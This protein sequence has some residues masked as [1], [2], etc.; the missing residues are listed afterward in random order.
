M[1][2]EPDGGGK[3]NTLKLWSVCS[4]VPVCVC[5]CEHEAGGGRTVWNGVILSLWGCQRGCLFI[6]CVHLIWKQESVRDRRV[7]VMLRIYLFQRV[8]NLVVILRLWPPPA[9]GAVSRLL[10]NFL[11]QIGDKHPV[12]GRKGD[13]QTHDSDIHTVWAGL[14]KIYDSKTFNF[15]LTVYWYF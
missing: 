5:V 8:V 4:G 6:L 1:N 11:L 9:R 13:R 15:V 2:C 3:T 12:D 7:D 10:F 14:S